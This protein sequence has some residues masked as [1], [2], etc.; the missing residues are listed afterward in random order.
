MHA[1][2]SVKTIHYGWVIV[3]CGV[4][5]MFSCLGLARFAFGVLLPPMAEALELSYS[6]RGYIGT[7]YF[8]G[9]L[10]MVALAPALAKRAGFRLSIALGLLLIAGSM[11]LLAAAGSYSGALLCYTVTGVG[12]GAA[13]IPMMALMSHWFAPSLRGAATGVVIGG[14]GLGI[15]VSGFL[16]PYLDQLAGWRWGWGTLAMVCAGAS[17]AAWLLLRDRPEDKGLAMAGDHGKRT[18]PPPPDMRLSAQERRLLCHLGAVYCLFGLSYIVYG[19]FFV[20]ALIDEHGFSNSTAGQFW[21]WVG[22]CSLLSGPLFGKLS[23]VTTRKTGLAAAFA[24]QTAAYA[25]ASLHLGNIPIYLSVALYGGAVWSVPTI[26]SATVGDRLGPGR[27]ALGFSIITF[28]FAVGQVIGPTAAG[29]LADVTGSF[30]ISFAA[31]ACCTV[32]AAGLSLTLP[33]QE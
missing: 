19:T 9:Y 24:V 7:G 31:S 32:L 12:S 18:P 29:W 6:Q 3:A 27:A 28:F 21:S 1:D 14:N 16:V 15:L 5:V 25:L 2:Y 30:S 33:Q 17:L 26:M 13:N 11:G 23:D 20:T 10:A 4:L 22:A 8:I